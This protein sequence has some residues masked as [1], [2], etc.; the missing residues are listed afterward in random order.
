MYETIRKIKHF[1]YGAGVVFMVIQHSL[2][3]S[4]RPQ[5]GSLALNSKLTD[6]SDGS[7]LTASVIAVWNAPTS[8]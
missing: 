5:L 8:G 6:F 1:F 3:T 7:W 4:R 2:I